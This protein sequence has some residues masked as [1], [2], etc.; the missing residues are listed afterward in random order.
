MQ[1]TIIHMSSFTNS[2]DEILIADINKVTLNL[3]L[4]KPTI[5]LKF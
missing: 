2:L 4:N 3:A 5:L 1:P